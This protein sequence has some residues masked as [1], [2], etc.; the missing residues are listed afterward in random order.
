MI[1]EYWFGLVLL[2]AF[3]IGA[4]IAGLITKSLAGKEKKR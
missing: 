4:W 2:A 3:G 1:R